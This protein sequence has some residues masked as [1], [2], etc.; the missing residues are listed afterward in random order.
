M[1]AKGSALGGNAPESGV[2][3]NRAPAPRTSKTAANGTRRSR[4][5]K[6]DATSQETGIAD[7]QET[8]AGGINAES[9]HPISAPRTSKT[10]A[11]GTRRSRG[12]KADATSQETGIADTQE[13]SAGGINAESSH[14]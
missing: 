8:S 14:P 2:L 3:E 4:G 12:Y 11:N 1:S 5:Y 10:A 9:S 6:A 13:T 7:T